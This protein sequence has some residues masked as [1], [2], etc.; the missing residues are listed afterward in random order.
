[1]DLSVERLPKKGSYRKRLDDAFAAMDL[2]SI[3]SLR[4]EAAFVFYY[5]TCEKLAKVMI[6][7]ERGKPGAGPKFRKIEPRESD[8]VNACKFVGCS[9]TKDD[10]RSIFSDSD[11]SACRLRNQLFHDFGPTHVRQ[12]QRAAHQLNARMMRFL[13]CKDHV[14]AY[15]EQSPAP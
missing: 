9:A 8:V 15:L 6:G 13:K 4:P 11:G 1:L 12:V 5:L 7:I 14:I 10:I 3:H 2:V